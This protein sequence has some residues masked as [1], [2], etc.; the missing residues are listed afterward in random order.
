MT[1][2]NTKTIVC[3]FEDPGDYFEKDD[4]DAFVNFTLSRFRKM[5]MNLVKACMCQYLH[6]PIC[7]NVCQCVPVYANMCQYADSG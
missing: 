3:T 1:K 2:T 7:A 4:K 5:T 6:V